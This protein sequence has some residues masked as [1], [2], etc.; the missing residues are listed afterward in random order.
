MGAH[1][2][3]R[4]K[5]SARVDVDALDLQSLA[6]GAVKDALLEL[7]SDL[8]STA[9]ARRRAILTAALEI[10]WEQVQEAGRT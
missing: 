1:L 6:T 3:R 7:Q 10:G 4:G 8:A 5:P 9:D 2:E